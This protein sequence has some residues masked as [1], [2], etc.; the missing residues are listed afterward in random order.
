MRVFRFA[1][2][3]AAALALSALVASG[4]AGKAKAPDPS[5]SG[6]AGGSPAAGAGADAGANAGKDALGGKTPEQALDHANAL[7]LET[8]YFDFDSSTLT[9]KAQENLRHMAAALKADASLR[10]QVE[11]HSDARGSNEY[12]LSLSLKRADV[13]RDFLIS[14]GV[15]KDSLLT[16]GLGEERPA[17]E[18]TTEDAY[19]KNRRGEF[20]KLKAEGK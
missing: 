4:C 2:C 3:S 1:P 12:N 15:A 19:A 14:E 17:V 5:E 20:R 6:A 7:S 18:G 8:V 11:G 9:D 16:T 13:I 10:L